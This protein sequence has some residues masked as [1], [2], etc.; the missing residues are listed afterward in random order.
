MAHA[1]DVAA[2]FLRMDEGGK[3][4]NTN[5]IDR[6]GRTFYEGNA[7]L[8]KYL[9]LAQNI[10]YAKTSTP[11]FDD[12]IYAYDNGGIVPE[13]QENYRVLLSRKNTLAVSLS[14][15]VKVFLTKLFR[16]LQN[17]PIDKLIDLSHED[18]EWLSKHAFFRKVDQKMDT[19]SRLSEY[20]EQYADII[21]L[22]DRM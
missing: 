5:V 18:P 13:I 21:Y 16:I 10:Y 22:M 19:I 7:R 9:H 4:F 1:K 3:L 12:P 17:A 14:E 20:K 8:N 2:F 15:D 6:N 11:L